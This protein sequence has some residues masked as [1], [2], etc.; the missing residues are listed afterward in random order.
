VSLTGL[1]GG[2]LRLTVELRAGANVP[3]LTSVALRLPLGLRFNGYRNEL[4]RNISVTG[5][6]KFGVA[7]EH[8]R[9]I[10][11]LGTRARRISLTVAAPSLLESPVLKNRLSE[12]IS[13]N[14]KHRRKT[15][16]SLS[17]AVLVADSANHTTQFIAHVSRP[18]RL[19]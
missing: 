19:G 15:K 5:L 2:A 12:I 7:L 3:P 14:R 10:V 9:L 1:A 11:A 8:G 4:A 18:Y 16:L 17:L 6:R 13:Y